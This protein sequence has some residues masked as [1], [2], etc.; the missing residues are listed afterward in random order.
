MLAAFH[1]H[2]NPFLDTAQHSFFRK[3]GK[4]MENRGLLLAA[5]AAL[6]ERADDSTLRFVYFFLLR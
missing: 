2:Y 4:K 6:L 5:I 1:F 3:G